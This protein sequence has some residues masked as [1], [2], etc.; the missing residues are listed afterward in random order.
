MC[1]I[2]KQQEELSFLLGIDIKPIKDKLNGS[3]VQGRFEGDADV[4]QWKRRKNE[5]H[6][7]DEK[8]G[9][10]NKTGE[11]SLSEKEAQPIP[12]TI[13]NLQVK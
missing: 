1:E 3:T 8:R 13:S 9:K 12:H 5:V 4:T 2:Q 6:Y 10:Q 11:E 7:V